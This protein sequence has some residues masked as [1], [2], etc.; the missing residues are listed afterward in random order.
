[1]EFALHGRM[2]TAAE[3]KAP[4]NFSRKTARC[5]ESRAWRFGINTMPMD[6]F[7]SPFTWKNSWPEFG[8]AT[9]RNLA[10]LLVGYMD[11]DMNS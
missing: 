2:I 10:V 6:E 8:T 3:D 5:P 1:M 9:F 7:D 11:Y 4:A